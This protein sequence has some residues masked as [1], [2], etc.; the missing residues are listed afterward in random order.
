[1]DEV[2]LALI[3]YGN[4]AQGLTQILLDEGEKIAKEHGL[5]CLICA[6]ADP[7]KGNAFNEEGLDPAEL[8]ASVKQYGMLK[9]LHGESPDWDAMEMIQ[10]SPADVV[11]EMSYTNLHTGEPSNTYMAEALRRKKHVITTNKGP[12]ALHYDELAAI[13]HLHG[14][15]IGVEGT[16]MSGTP[17]LR[18]GSE[19]L[20]GA[21]IERIQGI[22]NGTT[23]YILTQ[24]ENGKSYAE[25]L[26]EAQAQ[27]YAE[28]D[29]TGDVEGFDAA[30][31]VAIL[32]RLVLG[33]TVAFDEI[34]RQGISQLRVEDI[35]QAKANGQH[36]KLVGCLEVAG[37]KVNASVRPQCLAGDHPLARIGGVTNAI[38]FSTRLLGDV[39]MIGPGAGRLQTGYAILQDLFSIYR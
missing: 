3:G 12:I 31:K 24:M 17:V 1:M 34:D 20:A 19:L 11:V 29:P 27:G 14:V 22:L 15:S 23:N 16:V 35:E 4:V 5:R 8:L 37:G 25:A 13:A 6:I 32:A 36:W 18:V 2:R 39:S 28:A 33:K 30:A 26:A 21:G 10:N 9:H 7:L 38:V